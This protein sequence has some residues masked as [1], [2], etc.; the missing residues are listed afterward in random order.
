MK[1]T[2]K[3][4]EAFSEK[5]VFTHDPRRELELT[6]E[7]KITLKDNHYTSYHINNLN[8]LK[9]NDIVIIDTLEYQVRIQGDN[10]QGST[11]LDLI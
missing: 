8:P 11:F 2:F 5:F 6:D 4:L 9:E 3:N 7:G 1:Y 10:I